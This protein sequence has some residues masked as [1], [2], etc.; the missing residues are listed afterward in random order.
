MK[1]NPCRPRQRRQQRFAMSD[2]APVTVTIRRHVK[3]GREGAFEEALREFIPQALRFPGHLGVQ[4]LQPMPGAA[5]EWVV[6]IKFQSRPHYDAF[7][8]SPEY[9]GW[10]AQLLELLEAEPV[11]Q[12]Q[13][14]LESWF[15]LPGA[16]SQP[17]LPRWKMALVT[18]LGVNV[19]VIGLVYLLDP[20]IG[21]WHRVLQLLFINTL[22]VVLLTWVL[23]PLLTRLFR[24]WL[25]TTGTG[26][27]A[28][29]TQEKGP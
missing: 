25:Y 24:P 5:P 21:A 16:V 29:P 6:V 26:A 12:E 22:V 18:W 27:P 28:A 17:V 15:A 7:R 20:A 13:C 4:V 2:D 14:G 8:A 3:R 9:T 23:M 1:V 11:Y 19:A 10:C